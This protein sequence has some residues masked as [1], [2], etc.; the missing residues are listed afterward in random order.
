M[1]DQL[2]RNFKENPPS[3]ALAISVKKCLI[4]MPDCVKKC[5]I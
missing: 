2:C 1:L 3:T 4:V 5:R